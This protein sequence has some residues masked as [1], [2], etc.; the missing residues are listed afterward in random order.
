VNGKEEFFFKDMGGLVSL[1][2]VPRLGTGRA[3]VFGVFGGFEGTQR[4]DHA[5]TST[6]RACLSAILWFWVST[7]MP[8]QARAV[9]V[10]LVKGGQNFSP[11]HIVFG[12]TPRKQIK[13]TQNKQKKAIK[14]VGCLPRSAHLE[15]LA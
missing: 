5:S 14:S 2:A 3:H 15:S 6:G 9:L 4:H 10:F 7:A 11:F 13:T 8:P 1:T 12:Q